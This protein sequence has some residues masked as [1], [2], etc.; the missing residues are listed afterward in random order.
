M[1]LLGYVRPYWRAFALAVL[2]MVLTA[3]TEPLFPALMKPLLDGSFVKRDTSHLHL[4]P[5]ALIGIFLLRG[6]LTYVASYSLAWVSNKVMVD[7]RNAMFA[8]LVSLPT[9]YYDAQ[10]S[11]ALISK[12]AYDVQ[13]LAGAATSVLTVLVR[14]SLTVVGL[15][16]WLLYL[17]WKLTLVTLV[18]VPG[19]AIAVRLFSRRLRNLSLQSMR[20]MGEIT[21]VIEESIACHKVMK[22]FGGRDYEADRFNKAN[23][24]LRGYSMRQAIAAAATVPIVQTFAA[25]ALA[26]IISIAVVQSASEEFTVGGF[27][28]FITAM[29][30][31]LAP[32]RHL[33]DVNAPLQRGLASAQSVFQ[34]LDEV[35]EED[36]GTLQLGR[37]KGRIEFDKVSLL[38]PG[39]ERPALEEVSLQIE[40]GQTVALVGRSGGGK[41]SLVNLLPRFYQANGGRILFDGIDIR[42]VRLESLRANIALV[43]QD[44]S[45]FNDTVAA[46]I[47]YGTMKTTSAEAIEQAAHAAHALEFI[48]E[49]PQGFNTQIGEKGVRL[50]GGQRQRLAIAR[51]LLKDAPVLLLDE[52]TSALD[53]ESERH[54]QAAL[55]TLMRG[56]TTI[57]IAHRLSTIEYADRIV[58][59]QRGRVAETGTHAELLVRNGLYARLHR[60]QFAF[61]EDPADEPVG[62]PSD[63]PARA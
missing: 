1:R 60:I 53:S 45:L 32:L 50:S 18:I 51:A 52:A 14:D 58:V 31:L 21:H 56:R 29:L 10:S 20:T 62:K 16:A 55:A 25:I 24:T 61:E 23:E 57:V 2:G 19:I 38:Y 37:V 34:L 9:R 35:P 43:S 44:V 41:T 54:V 22:I 13:G 49:M 46:N 40:P 3:A 33:A 15:L 12:I 27:V 6:V 26:I 48:R 47:A 36:R 63:E 42:E 4:I 8:R 30:M 28:S 17:N 59:L 5:L 7:V 39:S 11:G